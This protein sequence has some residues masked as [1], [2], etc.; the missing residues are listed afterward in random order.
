MRDG[1]VSLQQETLQ[2]MLYDATFIIPFGAAALEDKGL[3][4]MV[5]PSVHADDAIGR[6]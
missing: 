1:V 3:C 2:Q 4:A 6:S 5:L